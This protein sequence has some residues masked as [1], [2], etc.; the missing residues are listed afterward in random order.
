MALKQTILEFE[1]DCLIFSRELSRYGLRH[2]LDRLSTN[3]MIYLLIS[4]KIILGEE[5]I[6]DIL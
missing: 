4:K 2:W 6:S 5:S 1:E 3:L